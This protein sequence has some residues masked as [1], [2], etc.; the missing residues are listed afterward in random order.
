LDIILFSALSY[1]ISDCIQNWKVYKDSSQDL[2]VYIIVSIATLI[3]FRLMH[4]LGQYVSGDME[5]AGSDD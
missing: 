1:A 4:F 3:C 5:R 2:N